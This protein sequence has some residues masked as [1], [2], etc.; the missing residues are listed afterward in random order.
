MLI[1]FIFLM[2]FEKVTIF[3]G[4]RACQ[5]LSKSQS[6]SCQS[7]V[8]VL[9]AVRSWEG[10]KEGRKKEGRINFKSL[11]LIPCTHLLA[12]RQAI[13][14]FGSLTRRLERNRN[15]SH[16]LWQGNATGAW[17]AC[18]AFRKGKFWSK[19][20]FIPNKATTST[21]FIKCWWSSF[22]RGQHATGKSSW[23][24]GQRKWGDARTMKQST[25]L[26]VIF[27]CARL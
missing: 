23:G 17:R 26:N 22:A 7:L 21:A 24:T 6:Q 12:G 11:L 4:C 1:L 19:A 14:W 25:R 16:V 10:G 5:S 13:I 3:A 9:P 8:G 18:V 20:I 2:F 27:L 15:P